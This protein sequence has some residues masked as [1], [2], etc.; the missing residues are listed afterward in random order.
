MYRAF[1]T[2]GDVV[3]GDAVVFG[4]ARAKVLAPINLVYLGSL[5][6]EERDEDIVTGFNCGRHGNSR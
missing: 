3:R 6:I 1:R 5:A 4:V 2:K